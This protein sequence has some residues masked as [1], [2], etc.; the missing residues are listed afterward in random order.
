MLPLLAAAWVMAGAESAPSA[1]PLFESPGFVARLATS[2][3][4]I[5]GHASSTAHESILRDTVRRYFSDRSHLR[6]SVALRWDVPTPPGWA[7]VTDI[8]VRALSTTQSASVEVTPERVFVR[9]ITA[10]PEE[11]NKAVGRIEAALLEGM[12]LTHEVVVVSGQ[13]S[14]PQSCH[15]Q[16]G[17]LSAS[18]TID[19]VSSSSELT[20]S[21]APQLDAIV[22]LSVECGYLV[23]EVTG[24]TDASGNEGQNVALSQARAEAVVD[25]LVTRGLPRDRLIADGVGSAEP[26]AT[27]SGRRARRL[28]RR[29]EFGFLEP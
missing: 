14:Y 8:A 1:D 18:T 22:E 5:E 20:S 27:G 3:L 6:T 19:F 25:Y 12:R 11:W 21:A 7:L 24:H 9:G 16:L 26:I 29:V 10:S 28:N 23:L 4:S 13:T 2:T 15:Q 17:A